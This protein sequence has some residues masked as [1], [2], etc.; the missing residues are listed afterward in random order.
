MKIN[1]SLVREGKNLRYPKNFQK[2]RVDVILANPPFGGVRLYWDLAQMIV[3]KQKQ[4]AWGDGL[5]AAVSND[6]TQEFPGMKGFSPTNLKYMRN[7]YLFY[8]NENS[9]QLVGKIETH[10]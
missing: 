7:W 1:K 10:P 3:W 5:I 2:D 9:P 6:L 4:S 8:V